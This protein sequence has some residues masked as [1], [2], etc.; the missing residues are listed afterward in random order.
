MELFFLLLGGIAFLL[1]L[2]NQAELNQL[3]L[4][5]KR[6]MKEDPAVEQPVKPEPDEIERQPAEDK[7]SSKSQSLK[8]DPFAFE[9]DCW[10]LGLELAISGTLVVFAAALFLT[11]YLLNQQ[12]GLLPQQSGFL[13]VL[14][15]AGLLLGAGLT[16][17]LRAPVIFSFLFAFPAPFLLPDAPY[18]FLLL[19]YLAMLNLVALKIFSR[20]NWFELLPLS[21]FATALIYFS[22]LPLVLA[23][24][25]AAII[26]LWMLILYFG[27]ELCL[28]INLTSSPIKLR[29]LLQ[30]FSL[31]S[32]FYLGAAHLV[33]QLN[34][35]L[36]APFTYLFTFIY[37]T[38][39]LATNYFLT[40][41]KEILET[42]IFTG[43]LLVGVGLYHQFSSLTL[44]LI[45]F[46]G[47]VVISLLGGLL[48]LIGPV[49]AGF[50]YFFAGTIYWLVRLLPQ[51][52]QEEAPFKLLTN[53]RF[54]S[55]LALAITAFCIGG[56]LLRY[57]TKQDWAGL[58][59]NLFLL[60]GI[61]M[62]FLLAPLN[63]TGTTIIVVWVILAFL[64]GFFLYSYRF[65]A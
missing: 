45:L 11:I 46:S 50:S 64:F 42:F 14:L 35:D 18:L 37:L 41:K 3:R 2:R 39:G 53:P 4:K 1:A 60:T 30:L 52:P 20:Q 6:L 28:R 58:F 59:G 15:F 38:W 17:N 49:M 63:F 43:F 40:E 33:F 36:L 25:R 19:A 34:P 65:L 24:T 54:V 9:Y 32:L 51:T 7:T 16:Y 5:V 29:Y 8:D 13:I 23:P 21:L 31:G 57:F 62:L 10:R 55:G 56:I 47:A 12:L 61:I 26:F 48:N 44:V 22:S 27:H